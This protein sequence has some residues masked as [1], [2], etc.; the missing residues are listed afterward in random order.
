MSE[1]SSPSVE[2]ANEGE[3]YNPPENGDV[4]IVEEEVPVSEVVDEVQDGS[5]VV[6]ESDTKT[7]EVPKKSYASIVSVHG[8]QI[9]ESIFFLVYTF[10]GL[11]YNIST[12]YIVKT[13]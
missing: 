10:K 3:V 2:E 1:Q 11:I 5:E 8:Q 12:S 9:T 6:V 4:P 13:D 7:G